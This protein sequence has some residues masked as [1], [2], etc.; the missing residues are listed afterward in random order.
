MSSREWMDIST[1]VFLEAT[2][3]LN[4][5][6]LMEPS[7]LVLWTR[8]HVVAHVHY[9]AEALLRLL[10]WARTREPM[11]MYSWKGQR[12]T[13]IEHGAKLPPD[14]LRTLVHT[15]ARDL[16]AD[17]DSFP[18]ECWSRRVEAGHG[19]VVPASEIIWLRT[20]EVAVHAVDLRADVGFSDLPASLNL[21]MAADVVR[22]RGVA[23]EA[24]ELAEW[25]TGRA[26][27]APAL[28][29]WL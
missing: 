4:D 3:R 16:A 21:A 29:A 9:N 26:D 5:Q 10:H 11:A 18:R 14:Q 27:C 13:E 23:G 12:E 15:S 7:A 8:A 2:D 24:A 6:E 25:L 20:R 19:R 1:R 17:L 22:Q 28:A